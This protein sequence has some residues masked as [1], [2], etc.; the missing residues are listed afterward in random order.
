ML[1]TVRVKLLSLLYGNLLIDDKTNSSTTANTTATMTTASLS[2]CYHI[3]LV[4]SPRG[5]VRSIAMSTS[6]CLSV[7]RISRKSHGR[8]SLSFFAYV[9]GGRGS[10]L[11]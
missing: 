11:L 4:T 5:G 7:A 3:M 2:M 9:D 8:T 1:R 6:D 10:V